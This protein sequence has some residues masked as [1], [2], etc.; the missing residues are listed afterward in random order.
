MLYKNR[1]T[2]GGNIAGIDISEDID[3]VYKVSNNNIF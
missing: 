2:G 3:G 1:T